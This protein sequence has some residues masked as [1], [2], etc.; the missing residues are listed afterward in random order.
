MD[1]EK[2]LT[3]RTIKISSLHHTLPS[4]LI[5]FFANLNAANTDSLCWTTEFWT[6]CSA[7]TEDLLN[8]SKSEAPDF[9]DADVEVLYFWEKLLNLA[10]TAFCGWLSVWICGSDDITRTLL[11]L[12]TRWSAPKCEERYANNYKIRKLILQK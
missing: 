7:C 6:L 5:G 11:A 4:V 1:K 12:A 10:L 8:I 9:W 2:R 3:I